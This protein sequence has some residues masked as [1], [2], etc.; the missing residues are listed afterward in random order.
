MQIRE[1]FRSYTEDVRRGWAVIAATFGIGGVYD[2]V[3][4][5]FFPER[6]T[7]YIHITFEFI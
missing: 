5:Q 6:D 4:G 3:S 1:R 2:F 7:G